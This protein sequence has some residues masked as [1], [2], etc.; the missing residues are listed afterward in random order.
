M[1]KEGV[2]G[3]DA[4]TLRPHI[5]GGLVSRRHRLPPPTTK[6]ASKWSPVS[7]VAEAQSIPTPVRI[8]ERQ[9]LPEADNVVRGANNREKPEPPNRT[10]AASPRTPAT[11]QRSISRILQ[12]HQPIDQPQERRAKRAA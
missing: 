7:A 10:A 1:K 8:V 11:D 9:T 12:R 2:C 4:A 3:M 6:N 5:V